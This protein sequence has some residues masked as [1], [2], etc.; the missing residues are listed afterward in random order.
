MPR[1]SLPLVT[2][3]LVVTNLLVYLNELV[4]GGQKACEFYGLV[5]ERLMRTGDFG[6]LITHTFFHDPGT[7]FHLL[8]NMVFLVV[9]GVFIEGVLGHGRFLG[10]Y[11]TAGFLGGLLH[12]AVNPAATEPMVGASG[13]ICAVLAVATVLRPRLLGFAITFIGINLWQL[14]TATNGSIS[15]ATHIGGFATGAVFAAIFQATSVQEE[16]FA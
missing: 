2:F 11:V 12:V 3:I 6:T 8:G 10:L 4:D 15:V 16:R 1:R 9:F 14:L 13:S 7:V 5:P